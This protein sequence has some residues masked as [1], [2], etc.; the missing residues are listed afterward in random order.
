M[1]Y[2]VFCAMTCGVSYDQNALLPYFQA[3]PATGS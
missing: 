2:A 1:T 3:A